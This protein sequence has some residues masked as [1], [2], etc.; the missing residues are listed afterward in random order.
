MNGAT[1]AESAA[2]IRGTSPPWAEAPTQ[3]H[4]SHAASNFTTDARPY[5]YPVLLDTV[6]EEMS[7]SPLTS[8]SP[9]MHEF[10]PA[11]PHTGLADTPATTMPP[12]RTV[13]TETSSPQCPVQEMSP[14]TPSLSRTT[15]FAQPLRHDTLQGISPTTSA[16]SR[17]TTFVHPLR[18]Y[19]S[20]RDATAS[21][22][23]KKAL[24]NTASEETIQVEADGDYLQKP[25]V[26]RERTWLRNWWQEIASSI[27]S[28]ICL[29]AII[30]VLKRFENLSATKWALPITI[31]SMPSDK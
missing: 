1:A 20:M 5:V 21:T 15:T 13:N 14:A 17:A 19:T 6:H 27:I 7:V 10:Q 24:H 4:G 30:I 28:M 22:K 26:S 2:G 31:N 29:G 12:S 23:A 9:V 16:L 18:Q 3:D 8:S 25:R 11:L